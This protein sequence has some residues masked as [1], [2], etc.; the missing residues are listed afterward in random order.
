MTEP[1]ISVIIP[2]YNVEEYLD[3]CIQSVLN[4]T[5]HNLQVVLVDDGS[6]D[7]SGEICDKYAKLDPRIQV[8]HQTNAGVSAARNVGLDTALG[9]YIAFVDGDDWI[10][11]RMYEHLYGL[12]L[13]YEADI[14]QCAAE[15]NVDRN[16]FKEE[17]DGQ[18]ILY[19]FGQI[20]FPP[21][22][23]LRAI[24]QDGRAHR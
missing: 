19:R 7:K 3:K 18:K 16:N 12:M 9:D 2:V 13:Q 15:S 1:L 21:R 14:V 23:S 11:Q 6:K 17:N 22:R 5:Y 10:Y 24:Q 4:Q 8:I 20:L